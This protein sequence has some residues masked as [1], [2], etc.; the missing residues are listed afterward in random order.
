MTAT[1]IEKKRSGQPEFHLQTAKVPAHLDETPWIDFEQSTAL[2]LCDSLEQ[3]LRRLVAQPTAKRVHDT[4]VALRRWFSV[5]SVMRKDGWQSK[6]FKRR[7]A[8]PMR[9]LL[10]TLGSLRD[11][12]VNLSLGKE[13]GCPKEML[14]Q[15]KKERALVRDA[16]TTTIDHLDPD[17]T[18]RRLR[19]YITRR[20]ERLRSKLPAESTM[21]SAY[22]HIDRFVKAQE[23]RV[24]E[25]ESHARTPEELHQLRLAVK[26]WRY[27]LTEFFGLTNLQLVRTQQTLGKLNDL[28]RLEGLL[29]R[30]PSPAVMARLEE[31]RQQLLTEFDDIR[32]ALPY[33]LRPV[34]VS[35][36]AGPSRRATDAD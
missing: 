6:K 18:M 33:G 25:L 26:R 7:V 10:R 1:A 14:R 29:I 11:W 22:D 4:R 16:V 2:A 36:S 21:E 19:K 13:L 20:P 31:Q 17:S 28:Y 34:W 5:W 15:W 23:D 3:E 24:Q 30:Q 32:S 35:A 12:D 9:R 8:Q 27:L